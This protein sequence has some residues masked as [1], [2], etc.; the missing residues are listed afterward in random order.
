MNSY[1]WAEPV[2]LGQ[3]SRLPQI[4][5]FLLLLRDFSHVRFT[6]AI[7]FSGI[8]CPSDFLMIE[9]IHDH[10]MS[11]RDSAIRHFIIHKGTSILLSH[12][13]SFYF[14]CFKVAILAG[15][16]TAYIWIDRVTAYRQTGLG[17]DVL[18]FFL[19]NGD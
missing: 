9:I 10:R 18:C 1:K 5:L 19:I 2:I 3:S 15:M 17:H 13:L 7:S 4:A 14:K 6:L 16:C 12:F 11:L 8:F